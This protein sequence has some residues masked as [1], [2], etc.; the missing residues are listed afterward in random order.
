LKKAFLTTLIITVLLLGNTNAKVIEE[1]DFKSRGHKDFYI[2]D[3]NKEGCVNFDFS[4]TSDLNGYVFPI[5][6]LKADFPKD[7]KNMAKI[8]VLFNGV[9]VKELK[10]DDFMVGVAHIWLPKNNFTK[11]NSIKVCGKTSKTQN[12]IG[13]LADSYFGVY[14][15][16]Y[17]PDS[18]GLTLELET[19][20]PYVGRVFKID[21]IARNYGSQDVEVELF[22]RQKD[23]EEKGAQLSI[24][25]G[26]TSKRGVVPKCVARNEN[27]E[28]EKPGVLRITYYA[29]PQ[30]AIE[31]SVLPSVMAFKNE[32]G[33]RQTIFSNTP[34]IKSI[35]YPEKITPQI[36]TK[37]DKVFA[38]EPVKLL[39]KLK[40]NS[41]EAIQNISLE[42]KGDLEGQSGPVKIQTIQP[43]EIKDV[44]IVAKPVDAGNYMINCVV[45]YNDENSECKTL[46]IR[47]EKKDFAINEILP[48]LLALVAI[49]A[50]LYFYTKKTD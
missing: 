17:F 26:E 29:V 15:T 38:L 8:M 48:L 6:T 47:I 31:M 30:Q 2:N 37:S 11:N 33:E 45:K 20:N 16:F 28:C 41:E 3:F 14:E 32:F 5:F 23:L 35:E 40:N 46:I 21:S 39:I 43:N 44:E 34:M 42:L 4:Y 27:S 18:D 24:L 22:Y 13:I 25:K 50:F 19:Y 1:F 49:I 10:H 9:E 12:K 36:F 7:P